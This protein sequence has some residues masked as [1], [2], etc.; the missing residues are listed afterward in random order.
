MSE[1]SRITGHGP[2]A[3]SPDVLVVGAGIAGMA[4]AMHLAEVGVGVQLLDTAPAIGGSMHLLDHTFPTDSCGICLMLPR[5]PAYCP[6]FE[7]EMH[8][9]IRLLP[10]AEVV[11]VEAGSRETGQQDSGYAPRSDSPVSESTR[12]PISE[13]T[14]PPMYQVTVRHKPRYVDGNKC[15]GCGECAAVCPEA[16]PHDHEGWLHPVKAIY[17]PAG[18][19]AVP[20]RWLIDMA[21]CTRC[22]LCV[23]ACPQGAIDLEMGPRE[24]VLDVGAV[25]LAPGFAPFEA[26]LKGEY[27]YGVYDNVVSSLEFERMVSLAGSSVGRLARPSDGARPGK[28]AFI[29]CVGSR[30]PLCGAAYCSSACC[31]Y[32]AKQVALAKQWAPDL[33]AT[34]FYMDLRAFGK[35]FEA[36]V[37]RVQGLPGVTYRRSMPSSVHELQ[38]SKGLRLGYIG[39]DGRPAEEDFDLVVLALGFAPPAGAQALARSLGV[40]LNRYG[41]AV[42]G[43]AAPVRTSQAGVFAAGAFREPKDI[44]ETVAEAAA[45]A[46]EA[47]AY[48]QAPSVSQAEAVSQSTATPQGP[49]AGRDVAEEEPR[50][51]VFVCECN[52]ELAALG[53]PAVVAWARELPGVVRAEAVPAGCSAEGRAMLAA[54]IE[55]EG[56]NRVVVGGCSPR[57]FG[58]EFAELMGGV[59]LDPRLLAR[60]NLREQVVLPHRDNG[61]G[62][63]AEA[64]DKARSL[65]GMAVAGLRSLSGVEALALGGRQALTRRALVVGGGAAGM[66]AALALARLDIG[67]DLVERGGELGGQWRQIRY[68]LDGVVGAPRAGLEEMVSQVEAE[69][70]IVVHRGTEV[71]GLSGKP[72]Q[73]RSKLRQGEQEQVVEHGVVVV[74]TG[75]GPAGGRTGSEYLYGQDP[76]VLT[77]RELE[78][79]I[80]EGTL[81]TVQSVV[82]IQC[83]GSREP[84]RPYCSRVCC[85]QAVKNALK[86]KEMR[87]EAE[88]YV[89]YREVRTYGFREA[90]YQAAREAGVVFLQYELPA[91][92]EVEARSGAES[93]QVRLVEP[94]TGQPLALD[95]DLLVLSVGIE[96]AEEGSLAEMLVV[97]RNGDGFFQEEHGKMKPLDLGQ[98]MYVAGLAHS[99]RFLEETVAQGQGAAMRAAAFLSPGVVAERATSVWVN[100]RLCSFCGLCVE[101]CPYE[102]RVMNYDRRVAEVDY[103]LCQGCGVCAVVCPNKATLQKAFEHKQLM[104]TIDMAFA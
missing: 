62:L 30:D 102:A 95:A 1:A 18:Q 71:V 104:S 40:A 67:V 74:A 42:T 56:L 37:E 86:L 23:E 73:Y 28:V 52:G 38:Q 55:A 12:L 77:Q 100:E 27:G 89:L 15:D 72:G 66:A 57:L 88:V 94:V 41:F 61:A 13:S 35:D 51:G 29:S 36:Y 83:V 80:A 47:A 76:R 60:V 70:R 49:E 17:R 58:A 21:Y 101:A 25:V 54:A 84:E 82:M 87:P 16:R 103:A 32:T 5:Q 22:G 92:P 8:E 46:A 90:A 11:G 19:R 69:G 44:P 4:A 91:K 63:G 81:A 9:G 33:E 31:M 75:G 7:C 79:Q 14:K 45:A 78:E 53:V 6:T 10:Y 93:L 48:V 64:L 2:R 96:P 99:P 98:G 59:G 43:E 3:T 68:Q 97:G 20:D 50:V 85:T 34:V 65:V 39:Q 26:R 24:E